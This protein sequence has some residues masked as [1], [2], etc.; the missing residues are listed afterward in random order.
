MEA[1]AA[2]ADG[3]E[4]PLLLDVGRDCGGDDDDGDAW[5]DEPALV[6]ILFSQSLTSVLRSPVHL[7]WLVLTRRLALARKLPRRLLR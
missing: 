5:A 6:S 2:A 3:G 4:D 1:S 7:R